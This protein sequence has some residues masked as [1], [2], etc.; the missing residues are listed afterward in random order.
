LVTGLISR[1]D[2]TVGYCKA[3][4]HIG[5][6][7]GIN[8]QEVQL[9]PVVFPN[10]FAQNFSLNLNLTQVEKVAVNLY[11]LQGTLIEKVFEPSSLMPGTNTLTLSPVSEINTGIYLVQI[12][13]GTQEKW[14]KM[15]KE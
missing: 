3:R 8:E 11:T 12:K 9:E 10:P 4:F 6:T 13:I 5:N 7:V 14:V 15:V 1:F 2:S